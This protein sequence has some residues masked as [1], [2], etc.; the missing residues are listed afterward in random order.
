MLKVSM[1]VRNG[2]ARFHVAVHAENIR[3]AVM[4]PGRRYPGGDVRV[5][6]PIDPEGFFAKDTAAPV[7]TAA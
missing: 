5:R 7:E 2:A 3:Q 6:F 1:E 4:I